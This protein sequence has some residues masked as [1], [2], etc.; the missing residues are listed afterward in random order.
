MLIELKNI[1]KYVG[2]RRL[3][4]IDNLKINGGDK[5]GV[6]G[7]NGVGKSTLLAILAGEIQPDEGHVK[8]NCPLASISQLGLPQ[9]EQAISPV[10]AAEFAVERRYAAHLSGGEIARYKIAAALGEDRPLL[11]ADEP[12][13]NLDI[14]GRELLQAK[15]RSFQGA[16]V[17]VSHD[18]RLLDAL[19]DKIW[20]IENGRLTV[21]RG[22]YSSY[23]E[24]KENAKRHREREYEKYIDKKKQL[25]KAIQDRRDLSTTIRKTPKRM[26]NSEAR[27]HKMGSQKARA[28]LD[29]AV[30]AMEARLEKLTVVEKP[31]QSPPM[32]FAFGEA[33]DLHSK[34]VISGEGI[35]KRFGDRTIFRN[36]AFAVKNG[37]KVALIGD[38]GCGKSTLLYMIVNREEPINLA[39]KAR[40]GYFTQ[41]M[42]DLALD[43]TL[44]ANVMAA[45]I[46]EE[47][48]VRHLLAR[49]LFRREDVFKPV[50][51]LSGGERA[52]VSLAKIIVSHANVL[53]LDEPTNYLDL[54]SLTALEEVLADYRGTILFVS[55]DRQFIDRV[56]TD[57]ILVEAGKLRHFAGNY[58]QYLDRQPG[59]KPGEAAENDLVL[60]YRLSAVLARLSVTKDKD[61]AAGLES[62]Y[63]RLL[64]AKKQ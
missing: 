57:L 42:D 43:K 4:S 21:Y 8:R 2:D 15:L 36:A 1:V 16:L 24:Q 53:L 14:T 6:I 19:C 9:L 37:R 45:S 3:L 40:I 20:E 49:L 30:K 11:L 7:R 62:E 33:G 61:E 60:E 27:L 25:E 47:A 29:K 56:A 39:P 18:R 50:G 23:L 63:R 12:A 41:G 38:N 35:T 48:A 10:A 28:N 5:I 55:H 52:R 46:H 31:T 22:N 59:E 51:V 44:L 17:M 34:I 13:A 32:S 58:R 54:S 64:A 26:G